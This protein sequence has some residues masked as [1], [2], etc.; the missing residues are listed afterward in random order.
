MAKAPINGNGRWA[1]IGALVAV[2]MF[3]ITIFSS[4]AYMTWWLFGLSSDMK[5]LIT[6]HAVVDGKVDNLTE[7]NATTVLRIR[8][9]ERDLNEIETQ[10]C[11][12]DQIRNKDLVHTERILAMLWQ[13]EFGQ[14]YPTNN[15]YFPMIC[16]RKA[17]K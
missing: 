16:N 2:G 12:N 5:S 10:F 3:C 14:P 4:I 7:A 15:S 13:K 9:V 17:D 6:N 1:K 11:A 8:T